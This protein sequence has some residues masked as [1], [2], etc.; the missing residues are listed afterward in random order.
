MPRQGDRLAKRGRSRWLDFRN[1]GK[2][3]TVRI[4][5]N[6]SRT[7]AREIARVRRAEILKCESGLTST[8]QTHL[9]FAKAAT[10]FLKWAQTNKR[11]QPFEPISKTLSN[12]AHFLTTSLYTTLTLFSLNNIINANAFKMAHQY[13]STENFSA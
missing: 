6:S 9:S 7:I 11:P 4:G 12:A 13:A 8:P 2:R 3:H 1:Q 5:S 10:E